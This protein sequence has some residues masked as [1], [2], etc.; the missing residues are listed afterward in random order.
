MG[1]NVLIVDGPRCHRDFVRGGWEKK[2]NTLDIFLFREEFSPP[3]VAAD[4]WSVTL[5]AEKWIRRGLSPREGPIVYSQSLCLM[6]E[7]LR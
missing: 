5:Y 3:G 4:L 6:N 1:T 7:V 2:S